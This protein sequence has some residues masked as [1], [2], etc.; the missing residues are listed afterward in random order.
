MSLL[1]TTTTHMRR[2]PAAVALAL[3]GLMFAGALG[4]SAQGG[5]GG[6]SLGSLRV[7]GVPQPVGLDVYVRDPA[8]LV[9]LGKAFFW[10]V[11]VG[12][13]GRTACASCH[14]H[15]GADHRL[16]NQLASPPGL[17][18][19]FPR[20]QVL[21]TGDFPFHQ[22]ADPGNNQ[23]PVTR[24]SR[25]VVGSAGLVAQTFVD[26][27]LTD[28]VDLGSDPGD[29]GVFSVGGIRLRQAT[30][31]NAPSVINA[32]FNVRNFW[33]GRARE[34]FTG[35]TP[36]GDS[37]E[38]ANVL[39]DSSDGLTLTRARL[40]Q[41]SL[42]SQAVGPPLNAVEMSYDGR[43]W[44]QLGKKMLALPP[45]ARQQVSASDS[46]LGGLANAGGPGVQPQHNY[47]SLIRAA[48]QP[49]YWQST[50]VVDGGRRLVSG[51][52]SPR[53]TNEFTQMEANFAL[54][55]AVAIQAYESTLVSD[56]TRLDRFLD[57]DTSA[58]TSL[59]RGGLRAF[60]G[61]GR[62]DRC[63]QGAELTAAGVS[64]VAQ[65][66]GRQRPRDLGFFRTGVSPPSDD[67]GGGGSDSF[68]V[69]FFPTV[70][71][72][73]SAGVFKSPGLRNVALT[74][75]YFHTG[76]AASLAQVVEF[77]TR[78]GDFPDQAVNQ[79]ITRLRINQRD[80]AALIAFMEALTDD[81]VAFERAPFDHPSLCVPVGHVESSPGVP[82]LDSETD[83]RTSALDRWALIPA[84][85]QQGNPVPLQTF[86]EFL[87]GVGTDGSRAHTL[88]GSCLP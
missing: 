66:D 70:G 46:V 63:H 76:G 64:T 1:P 31:R 2:S 15:A 4:L 82:A 69:P 19:S 45:L 9:Q 16:Q 58:L 87:A 49:A 43:A 39:V 68:G 77:Y 36:F 13:D 11:Q 20:N 42:A 56:D 53:G 47:V 29:P 74:G 59:E 8:A 37:D 83:S 81:R 48:F 10:D 7:V 85:G 55:W 50:Q 51:I 17:A 84:S 6:A 62:C 34:I 61:Q 41:S 28:R 86:E 32:V 30:S 72:D 38:A 12:S 33:D 75:P 52:D 23:S 80:G 79:N 25:F 60:G 88:Q 3:A 78:H 73:N 65:Q 27:R 71:A 54:F 40:D 67:V 21:S 57:G 22:F 24:D 26:I 14:F 44:A 18:T 5:A 35:A